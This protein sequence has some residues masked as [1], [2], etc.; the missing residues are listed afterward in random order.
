MLFAVRCSLFGGLRN[1]FP[2]LFRELA[3]GL[4]DEERLGSA[5]GKALVSRIGGT[6]SVSSSAIPG[7]ALNLLTV[8][9][10]Q[11]K[12]YIF[13]FHNHNIYSHSLEREA[14]I[15]NNMRIDYAQFCNIV[16]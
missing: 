3:W 1:P 12:N 4:L 6:G 14:S 10:F 16:P 9:G 7:N 5:R 2:H 11:V 15:E 8:S 13:L